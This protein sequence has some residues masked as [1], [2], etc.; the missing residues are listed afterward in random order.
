ML[1]EPFVAI[2]VR[3]RLGKLALD[4]TFEI[5]APWTVLFGPS[6]SGKST[7]LRVIA[8]L[9]R[10]QDG[11]VELFGKRVSGPGMWVPAHRRSMRWV[12][13]QTALFPHRTVRWNLALGSEEAAEVER[14]LKVFGLAALAEA[15]PAELSGGQQ[16]RVSVVRAAMGARGGVLLLDEPFSGLDAAVREGLRTGLREWLGDTPVI[17]VTHDV[18]EAF[19]LGAEVVRVAEGRVVAQGPVEKVLA[20]EREKLLGVLG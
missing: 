11:T 19:L 10:P 16:Q 4:A 12:A 9:I 15:Y 14:A 2:D 3:H 7:I 13:Q 18:G 1:P 20:G 5:T 8:G 6:G 17:S